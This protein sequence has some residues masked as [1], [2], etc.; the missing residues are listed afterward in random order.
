MT[1]REKEIALEAAGRS[2]A[3]VSHAKKLL[4]ACAILHGQHPPFV[5]WPQG[6]RKGE[7]IRYDSLSIEEKAAWHEAQAAELRAQANQQSQREQE[8]EKRLAEFRLKE[9]QSAPQDLQRAHRDQAIAE[10][11][12]PRSCPVS[13]PEAR[14]EAQAA[15]LPASA[16]EPAQES[17]DAG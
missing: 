12:F 15:G 10:P 3:P 13:V 17:S 16:P 7:L 4:E 6:G 11:A 9:P 2:A 5:V 1:P 8:R 14:D